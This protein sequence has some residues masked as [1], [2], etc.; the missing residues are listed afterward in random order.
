MD[1]E[2]ADLREDVPVWT[3]GHLWNGDPTSRGLEI[4]RK[5]DSTWKMNSSEYM[6]AK[7][8]IKQSYPVKEL[9]L[10][11]W[12][13]DPW[14]GGGL[15]NLRVGLRS[16]QVHLVTILVMIMIIMVMMMMM[17][18]VAVVHGID[19]GLPDQQIHLVTTI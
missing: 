10:A 13:I 18:V 3:L 11:R 16:Q 1:D 5:G 17:M 6:F 2:K 8:D 14:C 4:G 12:T 9:L 19:E 7:R 15:I